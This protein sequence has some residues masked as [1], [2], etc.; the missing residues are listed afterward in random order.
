SVG[1][2]TAVVLL[3]VTMFARW[4][5][6]YREPALPVAAPVMTGPGR[7][8]GTALPAR[9]T[10]PPGQLFAP[11]AESHFPV[12]VI[13]AHGLL[14][15]ATLVGAVLPGLGAGGGCPGCGARGGGRPGPGGPAGGGAPPACRRASSR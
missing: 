13:A 12:A 6:V 15:G 14:A 11:P 5:P 2:L 9:G 4:L 7:P 1:S 8:P 3:G 10:P